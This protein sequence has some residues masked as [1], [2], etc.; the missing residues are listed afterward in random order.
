MKLI[1]GIVLIMACV[2][3]GFLM[4]HGNLLTL[5]VPSEYLIIGGT[6][7]GSIIIAN[8]GRVC[9]GTL[10]GI[11]SLLKG[12]GAPGRKEY[13]ETLQMLYQLFQL[14]RKEGGLAYSLPYLLRL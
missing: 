12:G 5:V 9:T 4:H 7:I 6:L 2:L 10:R 11:A 3:T 13:L 1:G 8:P 14:S